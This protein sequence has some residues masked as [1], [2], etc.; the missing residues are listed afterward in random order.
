MLRNLLSRFLIL[1]SLICLL[2]NSHAQKVGLV[3][4][5]GGAKGIAHIGVLRA[6]EELEIPIDYISGTSS[7][8]IVGALY[9]SGY[10][11]DQI[12]AIFLSE[13]FSRI[14][15]GEIDAEFNYYFKNNE[16][17]ASWVGI[18]FDPKELK[19]TTLPTS[20]AAP[21][22]F[23]L[24]LM[25][26]FARAGAV[27]ND[28]FDNLMIP[29]RCLASDI[30]NKE[31]VVF[32]N[33]NLTQ[34]VRASMSYPFY[35]E[36]LSFNNKVLFD[37]GLYNNFPSDIMVE[38][39]NPDYI[40]G[41]NVSSNESPPEE[42]DVISILRNMMISKSNYQVDSSCGVLIEPTTNVSSFSFENLEGLPD[43]GY[44]A[45]YK[46]INELQELI[47][48][49]RSR[50]VFE[51][52]RTDFNNKKPEFLVKQ[53]VPEDIKKSQA[54]YA[55]EIMQRRGNK[56]GMNE[57]LLRRNF[58]RLLLDDQVNY[59]FPSSSY[60]ARGSA[61]NVNLKL[62]PSKDF[63]VDFGGLLSSSPINTGYVGLKY[64][65]WRNFSYSFH[66]NTYFGKFYN[67]AFLKARIDIPYGGGWSLQPFYLLN[68]FNYFQSLSAFFEL[69]RPSFIIQNENVYGL[70]LWKSAGSNGV[71]KF[72]VLNGSVFDDYYQA[73]KFSSNDIPDRT[74]LK[75]W[76][77]SIKY[78][79]NTLN[80]KQFA[81]QGQRTMLAIRYSNAD[82]TFRPGTTSSSPLNEDIH[83]WFDVHFDHENFYKERGAI[84]FGYLISAHY[85]SLTPLS[86]Y[87]S[88]S[89][90]M[91]AFAPIPE[92]KTLFLESFRAF[93]YLAVGHRFV[94]DINNRFDFRLEA[95][96]FQPYARLNRIDDTRFE[97][98]RNLEKRFTLA[99]SSLVYQSPLGPLSLSVNY[100][101][102]NPEIPV[103]D[104]R[105]LTFIF[106]FGYT[107]FNRRAI[108]D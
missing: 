31:S 76:T 81:N 18:S 53:V 27:A 16:T 5:G 21:K 22:A 91:N 37:G 14:I 10:S 12:E 34:A 89:L 95:Y 77:G 48:I 78:E 6:L 69:D 45:T 11:P 7:G 54:H 56:S 86:N 40:I 33:G 2:Q 67:S 32:R 93:Q 35:F 38:D 15:Q 92:S 44:A 96:I 80:F 88:T 50:D 107:L 90:R 84:R 85:S 100:Y 68:R 8:A 39:F 4:S 98:I 52:M 63:D 94:I 97:V 75:L 61:F 46:K 19:K 79:S 104:R 70:G 49:R 1:C 59:I 51:Q 36:P 24:E 66:A 57:D 73:A 55:K 103:I 82:E 17:S 42:N 3:L 65:V 101:L 9:A 74:E 58:Y 105:P 13:K 60:Q 99:S 43:S 28:N 25:F 62:K 30:E 20:L 64:R 102:N 87:I 41:S 71:L 108:I 83:S 26:L 72:D 47:P 29:F 23:D 106:Q